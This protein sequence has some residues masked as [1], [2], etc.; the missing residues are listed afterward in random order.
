MAGCVPGRAPGLK[1]HLQLEKVLGVASWLE[2]AVPG[3]PSAWG[4]SL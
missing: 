2:S 3:S 1:T 4:T